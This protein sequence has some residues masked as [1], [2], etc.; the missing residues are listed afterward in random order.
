VPLSGLTLN[1]SGADYELSVTPAANQ[2]GLVTITVHIADDFN[3]K[4]QTVPLMVV[5]VNDRPVLSPLADQSVAQD[6]TITFT[7]S[8]ADID[9]PQQSLTYTLEPGAPRGAAI[10]P[11]TGLFRFTPDKGLAPG[12]YTL[13][14][15]VTDGGSPALS[16]TASFKVLVTTPYHLHYLPLWRK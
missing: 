14:V 16:D 6:Q 9:L 1:G 8:A 3:L 10:N 5:P 13:T 4:T 15:R 2:N 11:T 7:A 12:L